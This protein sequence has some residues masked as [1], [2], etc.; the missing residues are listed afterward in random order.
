[1]AHE[2]KC[3]TGS[4]RSRTPGRR[5]RART[6][7]EADRGTSSSA[8]RKRQNLRPARSTRVTRSSSGSGDLRAKK[9]SEASRHRP[10]RSG[11]SFR[12]WLH[13]LV[14]ARLTWLRRERLVGVS[15]TILI[16]PSG[17]ARAEPADTH[18]SEV[19]L[20]DLKTGPSASGK[21]VKTGQTSVSRRASSVSAA[22][23]QRLRPR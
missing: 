13:H 12:S 20:D 10:S 11:R 18:S 19:S 3:R 9:I 4:R 22:A 16:A 2:A 21:D 7:L 23:P 17:E 14:T 6:S 15:L 8:S 5:P 1:M